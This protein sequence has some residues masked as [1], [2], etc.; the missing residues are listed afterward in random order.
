[1]IKA[2]P[3][4]IRE[5]RRTNARMKDP[6]FGMGWS[7]PAKESLGRVFSRLSKQGKL[8]PLVLDAGSSW[9]SLAVEFGYSNRS[10]YAVI[11]L[12][13]AFDKPVEIAAKQHHGEPDLLR[14][15]GDLSDLTQVLGQPGID[16]WLNRKGIPG[17]RFSTILLSDVLNYVDFRRVISFLRDEHLADNGRI[18]ICNMAGIIYKSKLDHPQGVKMNSDLLSFLR[19]SELVEEE[20]VYPTSGRE[21]ATRTSDLNRQV[22]VFRKS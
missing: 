16:I 21:Y 1:M 6:R 13:V 11:G 14:V 18:V 9:S 20:V 17:L 4:Q 12:D 15:R 7:R 2:L 22:L 10:R 19:K 8:G 5:W 3:P